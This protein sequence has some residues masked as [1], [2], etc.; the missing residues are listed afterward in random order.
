M[1]FGFG[2]IFIAPSIAKKIPWLAF[3][4]GF[5]IEITQ[6]L[7]SIVWGISYRVIDINDTFWNTLGV[8]IGY[9]LFR[10][11]AWAFLKVKHRFEINPKGFFAY[12]DDVVN[13]AIAHDHSRHE[14]D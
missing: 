7:F 13:Q 8:L 11:F 12:V 10:I 2:V 4:V 3:S 6:L 1:P 14:L 5:G 9:G